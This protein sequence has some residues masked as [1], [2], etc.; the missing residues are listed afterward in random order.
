MTLVT[1]YD[2]LKENEIAVYFVSAKEME[3]VKWETREEL[4]LVLER[5]KTEWDNCGNT[6]PEMNQ[7]IWI[8]A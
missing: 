1:I 3:L 8:V 6:D 4:D 5:I 2:L 7:V